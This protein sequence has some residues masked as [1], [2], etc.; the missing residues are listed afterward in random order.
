MGVAEP[1][2]RALE[3][4]YREL[5]GFPGFGRLAVGGILAR[6]ADATWQVAMVLFVLQRFHSPTLA[7][8][9]VSLAI[10]PGLVASPLA[11]ALLDR[12]GRARLITLDYALVA[13]SLALLVSLSQA[14]L[15]T[16]PLLLGIAS[17]SS[18]TT[19]LS[20]GGQRSLIPLIVPE[21]HWD[22]GNALD[23]VAYTLTSIVGPA[24]GG[25][26]A[27]TISGQWAL[28]VIAVLYAA[29]AL[30]FTRLREPATE[31]SMESLLRSSWQAVRYVIGHAT[32]RGLAL[33]LALLNV[34][35]GIVVVAL[36]VQVLG[37]FHGSDFDVGLMWAL[38][39][40]SGVLLGLVAGRLGTAGRERAVMAWCAVL[41]A[42]GWLAVLLAPSLW[43]LGGAFLLAGIGTGPFDV[44]MFS[45]RQRRTDRRWFGR[46]FAISMSL[47]FAGFPIGSALAGPLLQQSMTFAL[48]LA[49][50]A[51]LASGGLILLLV[52]ARGD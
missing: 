44:A 22:R 33:S 24:L 3:Q 40:C 48:A 31:A 27:G 26:L 35:A 45:L 47:N 51:A 42:V 5:F 50:A 30:V 20:A 8:L 32:L 21:T 13:A 23:S 14:R 15:L 34:A 12:Y 49:V 11:G 10:L 7:G 29:A 52:P 28:A 18:L 6:L 16:P 9:T 41:S 38:Q 25:A 1:G 39:G 43:L 36:P 2:Q 37:R 17:L 4:G 19:M 46:A